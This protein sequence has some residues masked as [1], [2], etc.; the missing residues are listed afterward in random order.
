MTNNFKFAQPMDPSGAPT[1]EYV[2]SYDLSKGLIRHIHPALIDLGATAKMRNLRF[3]RNGIRKDFGDRGLGGV[4]DNFVLC[5]V[6]HKF[7]DASGDKYQRLIRLLRNTDGRAKTEIWNSTTDAWEDDGLTVTQTIEDRFVRAISVRGVLLFACKGSGILERTESIVYSN[8]FDDFPAANSLT[9]TGDQTALTITPS[10]TVKGGDYTVYF[11]VDLNLLAGSNLSVTVSLYI[12]G[13]LTQS[14]N[15]I[16]AAV[17][18]TSFP[19]ETFV[20]QDSDLETGDEVKIGISGIAVAG[21][22]ARDAVFSDVVGTPSHQATKTQAAE[23]FNDEYTYKFDM[24]VDPEPSDENGLTVGY[25]YDDGGGW[26]K[27]SEETFPPDY[28]DSVERTLVIDGMGANSK[29]G[30]NIENVGWPPGDG[31]ILSDEV[32]WEEST[33]SYTVDV[34]GY[35]LPTDGDANHGIEYEAETG[36]TIVL[37]PISGAPEATWI[38]SFGDRIIA[39]Q[40]GGDTQQFSASADGTHDNWTTLDSVESILVDTRNDPI[41]DLQCAGPLASNVLAVIRAR[42]IMKAFE[43]GNYD[44]AVGVNHWIE[45]IGTESPHSI[46]ITPAGLAFLGHDYMVYLLTEGG[47]NPIGQA[48]QQDMIEGLTDNLHRVDGIYDPVYQEYWLGVPEGGS[49]YITSTYIFD[50]GMFINSGGQVRR[51]RKRV[52]N[53]QRY[54]VVSSAV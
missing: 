45:G 23:A 9:T 49:N 42:S 29:F 18:S 28:A 13:I 43:T 46:S 3:E 48:I 21:T 10:G 30:L 16:Q 5:I 37:A 53:V 33:S 6:E 8:E 4:A 54:A 52:Q 32:T 20:F 24:F 2:E 40:D 26:T 38:E 35:N 50:V 44:L 12:K 22:T 1:P 27:H 19:G 25:Y 7:I 47:L 17:G 15:Y 51:W 34:H 31:Q 36:K 39:L 11:D 41:D 14:E